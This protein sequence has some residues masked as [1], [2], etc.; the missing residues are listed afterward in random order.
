M[1]VTVASERKGITLY[2]KVL[3]RGLDLDKETVTLVRT[4]VLSVNREI[5]CKEEVGPILVSTV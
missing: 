4:I 2:C 3:V 1:V 5:V